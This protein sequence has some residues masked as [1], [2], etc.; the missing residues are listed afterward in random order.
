MAVCLY[1]KNKG[2]TLSVMLDRFR[3]E[4]P[5]YM[6]SKITYAGRLDPMAQGLMILL[7]DDDVHRKSEFTDLDKVY[8]ISFICGVQTD[9]YDTL[10]I[11]TS[12]T[13][14]SIQT[15]IPLEKI[16]N[17][18]TKY[19][20]SFNQ[21]YPPY[22][23]KTVSGKPLWKH[24]R[25]GTLSDI[26]VPTRK[27]TILNINNIKTDMIQSNAL[28]Q[29]IINDTKMVQGDFRQEQII[30]AWRAYFQKVPKDQMYSVYTMEVHASSGTYMRSLVNMMGQDL[31]LGATVT[32]IDRLSIS[33]Y[34][35]RDIDK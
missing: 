9:T 28:Y 24:T 4:F 32:V 5:Q 33:S 30:A 13:D 23:S 15:T 27:V 11:I 8:R 17:I 21:P 10:G 19:I 31:G 20:S 14:Q 34:T 16:I 3:K 25:D 22:S 35:Q 6:S 1:Y 18:A 7:T 2:E 29:V 26:I 12:V